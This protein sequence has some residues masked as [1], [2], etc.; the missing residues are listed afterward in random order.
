MPEKWKIHYIQVIEANH[1]VFSLD[2]ADLGLSTTLHHD[3]TLRTQ[4]PIYVKQFKIPEAHMTVVEEHLKEWLK[5]GIVEPCRSKYNSPLFVVP[6]KD[7][8]L[9]IV[10]DFRALNAETHV[11]KYSMHD[12]NECVSQIGR[13]GSSIF[14]TL[15]LTSG[16]WQMLLKPNSR[17]FT[18]FTVPG[19]GQMRWRV[20][21]MGLLG[22][23]A[24][25][26]RLVEAAMKGIPNVIVYTDDLLVHTKTHEEH[27]SL[28]HI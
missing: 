15:D 27:L 7:G 25:F 21:P 9:R 5:L 11:D 24:S 12:V 18:A 14:S 3:I 17:D 8:S 13:A 19:H 10:Q 4:E 23:P 1:T 22:S 26:Q 28:I 2:K 6:K 16:F 20:A